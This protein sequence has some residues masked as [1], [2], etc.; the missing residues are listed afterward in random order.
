MGHMHAPAARSKHWQHVRSQRIADHH[1]MLRPV[2]MLCKHPR[3]D[4]GR[5]VRHNFDGVK[6]LTQ[7]GLCQFSFLIDKV[8]FGN[9]D[10]LE[11]IGKGTN[12]VARALQQF[13]RMINS[14]MTQDGTRP[15]VTSIA[16]S[17]ID[18][19]KPFTP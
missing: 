17:I 7:A 11:I 13:N 8:A 12:R 14:E 5:L 9:Q 3:I 18:R 10:Q 2:S 19:T 4:R 15:S 16:V 1:R 6:H